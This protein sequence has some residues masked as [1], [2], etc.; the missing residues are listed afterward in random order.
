[1]ACRGLVGM[2]VVVLLLLPALVLPSEP[3]GAP[4]MDAF[5]DPLPPDALFRL[6]TT[7]LRHPT[8]IHSLTFSPDGRTLASG[9]IEGRVRLWDVASGKLRLEL[10]AEE[11]LDRLHLGDPSTYFQHAV[12]VRFCPDGKRLATASGTNTVRLWSLA[13]GKELE[14]LPQTS[15]PIL[16][17][18][19][20]GKNI[21]CNDE[22]SSAVLMID[23]DSKK[24][25]RR[26]EGHQGWWPKTIATSP[27]GKLVAAGHNERKGEN[28][29][30][31][32]D[33]TTSKETCRIWGEN[34]Q[35]GLAFSSA[36]ILAVGSPQSVDLLDPKTKKTLRKLDQGAKNMVAFDGAGKLLVTG[37]EVCVWDMEKNKMVRTMGQG[38]NHAAVIAVSPDGKT[39]ASNAFHDERIR[40]WNVATGRELHTGSGH[41]D[42]VSLVAFSPDGRLVATGCR[43][44]GTVRLWNAASGAE[45]R[46]LDLEGKRTWSSRHAGVTS[47]AFTPAGG[48]IIAGK[49]QWEVSTGRSLKPLPETAVG[50]VSSPEGN[51]LFTA[52]SERKGLT[53]R[54]AATHNL[55][56][57]L[58]E[59]LRVSLDN[60]SLA[61]SPDGKTMAVTVD[62]YRAT[63]EE[64]PADSIQIWDVASAKVVRSFRPGDDSP[65]IAYSPNGELLAVSGWD[66]WQCKPEIW[67]ASTGTKVRDLAITAQND[68]RRWSENPPLVFSVD[69][70][71]L[72]TGGSDNSVVI[73]EVASG[74][75]VRT[76]QGHE[77]PVRHLAFSSDGRTLVSGSADT[78]ALVWPVTPRAKA[79]VAPDKWNDSTG[80]ALWKQLAEEAPIAYPAAWA[81]VALPQRA[82]ALLKEKVHTV[83]KVEPGEVN[84]LVTSLGSD[85][86]AERDKANQRLRQLGFRAKAA[87]LKGLVDMPTLE[88]KRRIEK[89]LGELE[90]QPSSEQLR[91]LR[92][93]AVLDNLNTSESEAILETLARGADAAPVTRSAQSA[94][95]RLESRRERERLAGHAP[96]PSR[97]EGAP[98]R[99]L[100]AHKGEVH[101][102]LFTA[103]GRLALSAGADAKIRRWD[104]AKGEEL[105]P[106][107][108]H[109]GGTYSLSLSSDGKNLASAGADGLVRLWSLETGRETRALA[110]HKG[111]VFGVAW[112]ANGKLLV[113]GGLDATARIW[114]ASG[115][116]DNRIM[117]GAIGRITSV[118][119]TCDKDDVLTAGIESEGEE[120]DSK[121]SLRYWSH[122][123][124]FWRP[125]GRREGFPMGQR[126]S[127]I[128]ADE[129]GKWN[130]LGVINTSTTTT[131]PSM[132]GERKEV[133]ITVTGD[134]LLIEAVSGKTRLSLENCGAAVALSRDGWFLATAQGT[135]FHIGGQAKPDRTSDMSLR[136]WEILTGRE[137][138]RFPGEYP[139][140]I[141]LSPDCRQVLLGFKD[142]TISVAETMPATAKNSEKI[143]RKTLESLW[144]DLDSDDAAVT[145]RATMNLRMAGDQALQ[146]LAER[147]R[148]APADDP[149]L[150]RLV[151]QLN[152]E[153]YATRQ[154]ALRELAR[155]GAQ[156]KLVLRAALVAADSPETSR[157]IEDLLDAPGIDNFP[158]PLRRA[159]AAYLLERPVKR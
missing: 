37:G 66:G 98:P 12:T 149:E 120:P 104:L 63:S 1:M 90:K 82:V 31:V 76:L 95:I 129:V 131:Y 15:G 94:L 113:S 9:D 43:G 29:T 46:T 10:P 21:L 19:A 137:V 3:P 11:I 60:R 150:N 118:A 42:D 110:G 5:G 27:D 133:H 80:E 117:T 72:A 89:L 141:A 17:F 48:T 96:S 102:V 13:D 159:R 106:L 156:A 83:P 30:L 116:Q 136:L 73:W 54:D 147:L 53:V 77:R 45:L 139:A 79:A 111:A 18:T 123:L 34:H 126:A 6:G 153:R 67:N 152:A 14:F 143:D 146:F 148:P 103:D 132:P 22:K 55:A 69:G 70:Q 68:G 28:L 112:N 59:H 75:I 81:L 144:R 64:A 50:P 40:L 61:L 108:G 65:F 93:V 58:A 114:Q 62:K 51:I 124:R 107:P 142:G 101:A 16:A 157:Q 151:R 2:S 39:I 38:D 130:A 49:Q 119:F 32:W 56:H 99:R 121:Y 24:V 85:T 97:P 57:Q 91:D 20:G 125:D 88:K 71:F 26:F 128:A 7:R 105:P 74:Q 115:K 36:G 145:Y 135:D 4:R 33:A 155:Q 52:N 122:F 23:I 47:L 78:T 100:Y 8:K 35:Q 86:F 127:M 158:D 87:L 44:D 92:A 140:V 25:L 41:L 138:L 154:T 134:A 109:P 84:R